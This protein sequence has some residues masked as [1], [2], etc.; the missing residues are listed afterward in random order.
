MLQIFKALLITGL[1]TVASL[2]LG[3]LALKI[4][5]VQTGPAGVAVFSM[6]RQLQQT[7]TAIGSWGGQTA[8]TQSLA[9]STPRYPVRFWT[10]VRLVVA[11]CILTALLLTIVCLFG[12]QSVLPGI[13]WA[14][15]HLTIAIGAAVA[16]ILFFFFMG[17]QASGGRHGGIAGAQIAAAGTLLVIVASGYFA[18]AEWR[19]LVNAVGLCLSLVIGAIYA[20]QSARRRGLLPSRD[21]TT[22]ALDWTVA[23][24]FMQVGTSS[25]ISAA[26]ATG[27]G[28]L[29][30]RILI[31][32][33]GLDAAGVFDAA[34]TICM[35]YVLT[36]LSALSNVYLP[37]LAACNTIEE[38]RHLLQAVLKLVLAAFVPLVC[39]MIAARGFLIELL[40]SPAFS[41]AASIIRWMLAADLLKVA[42][43]IFAMPLL[44]RGHS[45]LFLASELLWYGLFWIGVW[46]VRDTTEALPEHI[47]I[48]YLVSYAGYWLFVAVYAPRLRSYGPHLRTS[49][50]LCL[51]AAIP[52]AVAILLN[53]QT[54]R[55]IDWLRNTLSLIPA[56]TFSVAVLRPWRL[57]SLKNHS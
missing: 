15:A 10:L 13:H 3:A 17:V 2:G 20:W 51:C 46:M 56:L 47:G 55:H 57:I 18:P 9:R 52:V 6:L 22:A 37:K 7:A 43:F 31:Q 27:S 1:G 24:E 11:G 39:A 50:L 16:G 12:A 53:W 54:T 34:W 29:I 19:T 33:L 48:A 44:A 28:L 14:T 42:G 45:R 41:D 36:L 49:Y 4:M 21:P 26:L 40:Y 25:L 23:R 38:E 30:R 35:M 32:R 5:A 8:Y